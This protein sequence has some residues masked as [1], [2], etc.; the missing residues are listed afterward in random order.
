MAVLICSLKYSSDGVMEKQNDKAPE[1]PSVIFLH[2]NLFDLNTNT[3]VL[4][5]SVLEKEGY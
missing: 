2:T 3:S 5:Y 4:Q 1:I